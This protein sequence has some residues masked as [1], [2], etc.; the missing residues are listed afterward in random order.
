MNKI[1]VLNVKK[2]KS[3]SICALKPLPNQN[4]HKLISELKEMADYRYQKILK[5]IEVKK[6]VYPEVIHNLK[7]IKK[8]N[9]FNN[10]H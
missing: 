9:H 2:M 8:I 4:I 3:E 5:K 1:G 10:L 7:K 6:L